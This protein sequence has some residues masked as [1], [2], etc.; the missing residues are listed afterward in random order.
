M[1]TSLKPDPRPQRPASMRPP[2]GLFRNAIHQLGDHISSPNHNKRPPGLSPIPVNPNLQHHP[3]KPASAATAAPKQQINPVVIRINI[4]L[5]SGNTVQ[6]PVRLY[7]DPLALANEFSRSHNV[8]SPQVVMHLQKLF[9][10]Q[11]QLA[12]RKRHPTM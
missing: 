8:T 3:F 5:E 4:E 2:P 9:K 10:D 12:I 7:D 11:Q 6:V 1:A